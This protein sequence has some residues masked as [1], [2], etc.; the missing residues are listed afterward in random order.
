MLHLWA[1]VWAVFITFFGAE[2][3]MAIE[4]AQY[5]VMLKE[6]NLELRRYEPHI[7]A[8]TLVEGDFDS[9][10]NEAFDRLFQ[11]ISG[12]NRSREKIQMTSPVSQ[13]ATSQ[14]IDMT[15]PVG[16]QRENGRWAVSFMMPAS[17]SLET[18]PE[19]KDPNVVLRQVPARYIAAVRYS[20]FWS[21]KA[22]LTHK[23][24]L[25][26][27]IEKQGFSVTGEPVW[28]RYNP[29]FMPWFLRRNEILIP[30]LIPT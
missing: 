18:L 26:A 27:W 9:A 4:E 22:Y 13:E 10:G 3:A 15:S 17:F 25:E 23:K 19:P 7:L 30:V 16:Q 12:N 1:I 20:G 24:E 21:E 8:E 5:T 29:P 28:A 6:Q 11:Y 2:N 14:K